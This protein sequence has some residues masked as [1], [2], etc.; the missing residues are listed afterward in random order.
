MYAGPPLV[1][2]SPRLRLIQVQRFTAFKSWIAWSTVYD[3]SAT[4]AIPERG[5]PLEFFGA[6]DGTASGHLS[7][8]TGPMLLR[9]VGPRLRPALWLSGERYPPQEQALPGLRPKP[10]R[11]TATVAGK[12]DALRLLPGS[13][14]HRRS[15]RRRTKSPRHGAFAPD[16]LWASPDLAT[17][18]RPFPRS[19]H[20][21]A[22][23][24]PGPSLL[25]HRESND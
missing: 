3:L 14:A 19:R 9:S 11:W 18:R 21:L 16:V 24:L 4:P 10:K 6:C 22:G 5:T 25:C 12:A 8:R 23:A 7:H 17:V 13:R 20:G 1:D 2:L 15:Y